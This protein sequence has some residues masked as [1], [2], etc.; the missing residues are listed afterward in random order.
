[1]F[2]QSCIWDSC[3]LSRQVLLYRVH[4]DSYYSQTILWRRHKDIWIVPMKP[5]QGINCSLIEGV[6]SSWVAWLPGKLGLHA[7][8]PRQ[9]GYTSLVLEVATIYDNWIWYNLFGLAGSHNDLIVLDHFPLF[10]NLFIGTSPPYEFMIN[11]IHYDMG[12]YLWEGIHSTYST[13][14]QAIKDPKG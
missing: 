6:G 5:I 7:L 9:K 12:Y 13:L 14:I 4:N 8:C 2:A 10:K 1:M 11:D 3:G